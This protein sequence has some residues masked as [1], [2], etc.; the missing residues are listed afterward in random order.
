MQPGAESSASPLP[1]PGEGAQDPPILGQHG[2]GRVPSKKRLF[3]L[4]GP[5]QLSLVCSL[6]L[7]G[8][9]GSCSHTET[10]SR[11]HIST[12][13]APTLAFRQI[14]ALFGRYFSCCGSSRDWQR[15]CE[16]CRS[17][18]KSG[19]ALALW[20]FTFLSVARFSF[21]PVLSCP[22]LSNFRFVGLNQK[23]GLLGTFLLFPNLNSSLVR[24]PLSPALQEG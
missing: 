21:I 22:K 7:Q 23:K 15:L 18:A 6:S 10:A 5:S 4:T 13:P 14:S 17:A 3:P 20:Y 19:S 12:L 16:P 1:V 11:R 9:R 2:G 24:F 8:L